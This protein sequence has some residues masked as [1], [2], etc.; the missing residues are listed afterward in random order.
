MNDIGYSILYAFIV[1]AGWAIAYF[2]GT[3]R[4]RTTAYQFFIQVN[5]YSDGEV[6]EWVGAYMKS[7]DIGEE[8]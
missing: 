1:V 2:V 4:G 7:L 3:V 8:E 5:A 6:D